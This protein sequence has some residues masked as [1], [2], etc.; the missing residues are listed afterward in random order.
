MR[1]GDYVNASTDEERV[2]T[3]RGVGVSRKMLNTLSSLESP[4]PSIVVSSTLTRARQTAALV[5]ERFANSAK[6]DTSGSLS[7]E[8]DPQLALSY[9]RMIGEDHPTAFFVGHDP[10]FT[11]LGMLLL[12]SSRT[13]AP[14][15]KSTIALFKIHSFEF[16]R[17][18]A[19]LKLFL[20]PS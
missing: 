7:P 20:S 19:E 16:P 13:V 6:Q 12:G 11:N 3:D 2:L 10:L 4:Q 9:F 18:S 14:F 8:T 15:G 5:A 17:V 1:H